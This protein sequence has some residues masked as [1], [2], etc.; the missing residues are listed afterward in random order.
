MRKAFLFLTLLSIISFGALAQNKKDKKS[1]K[2]D[3]VEKPDIRFKK[4]DADTIADA[5]LKKKKNFYFGEKTRKYHTRK[6]SRTAIT[7]EIFNILR[8]S[9]KVD[10]YVR[11]VY[12]HDTQRGQIV[13]VTGRGQTLDRVLHGPYEKTINDVV[14]EQGMYYYGMKHGIWMYQKRDSTLY[15]KYHFNKGWYRDSKITYYDEATKTKIKEVIP[16][17]Y[18]KREGEYLLFFESGNIAVRGLYEFDRKVGVWEEY[19]NI[20]GIVRI[21]KEV[22][23]PPQFHLKNFK[24]FVRKEWNRNATPT[25]ISDRIGQ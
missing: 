8:E 24:P 10:R 7:F 25:Y 16:Y 17:R 20:P 9:Q 11:R 19:H 2:K 23:Y 3:E 21:K 4:D 13:G 12:Y 22:Q 14:V 18:G 15:E 6:D 1:K 5:E